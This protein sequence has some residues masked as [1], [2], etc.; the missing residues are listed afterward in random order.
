MAKNT[1]SSGRFDTVTLVVGHPGRTGRYVG[2]LRG[3]GIAA[4]AEE[5]TED[6]P[7]ERALEWADSMVVV[8]DDLRV[9]AEVITLLREFSGPSLLA[10]PRSVGDE[11]ITEL[12]EAGVD[13]VIGIEAAPSTV[14]AR[15]EALMRRW[16]RA[17]RKGAAGSNSASSAA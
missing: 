7:D 8:I 10:M 12:L 11:S 2:S 1:S 13:A 3:R 9:P 6:T 15:V 17:S 4:W 5:I 16:P 14:A